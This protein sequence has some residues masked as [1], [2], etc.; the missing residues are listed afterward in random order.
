MTRWDPANFERLE[1]GG[2]TYLGPKE[3]VCDFC[4]GPEPVWEYPA[5]EMEIVGGSLIDRSDDEWAACEGCHALLEAHKIGP[6][7]E[8]I[9]AKHREMKRRGDVAPGW[10]EPPLPIHRRLTRQN[11]LRFMD[12]RTGPPRRYR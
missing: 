3:E 11:V 2:R 1:R 10:V 9:V 4:L 8:R 12:A 7:V 6:L 5:A